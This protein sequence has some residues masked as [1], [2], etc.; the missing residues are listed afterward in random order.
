MSSRG[1][2]FKAAGLPVCDL[3]GCDRLGIC[4]L[5]DKHYCLTHKEKIVAEGLKLIERAQAMGEDA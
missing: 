3:E 4:Q 2:A 1:E 5:V